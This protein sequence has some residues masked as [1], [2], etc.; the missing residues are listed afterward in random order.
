LHNTAKA[1][2][3]TATARERRGKQRR[4]DESGK[5]DD[6]ATVTRF[7]LPLC[8]RLSGKRNT[9]SRTFNDN[10]GRTDLR[11]NIAPAAT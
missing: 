1:I 4:V 11:E 10:T 7:T 9:G 2:I 8:T 6:A 5:R 3:S